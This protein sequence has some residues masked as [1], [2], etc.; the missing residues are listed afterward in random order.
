[1]R[2]SVLDKRVA[3]KQFHDIVDLRAMLVCRDLELVAFTIGTL[4]LMVRILALRL[5]LKHL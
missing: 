3:L 2:D 1:M 5:A 4:P